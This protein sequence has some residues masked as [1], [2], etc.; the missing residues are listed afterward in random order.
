MPKKGD[1][2]MPMFDQVLYGRRNTA[3]IIGQHRG[4]LHTIDNRIDQYYRRPGL[5]DCRDAL[6]QID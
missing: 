3:T 5:R 6:G 2:G 4:A 1:P